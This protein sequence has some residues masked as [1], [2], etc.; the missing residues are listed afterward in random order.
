M[1]KYFVVV[2]PRMSTKAD[3]DIL[4]KKMVELKASDLFFFGNQTATIHLNSKKEKLTSRVITNK[5]VN[6]VL[7]DF[8]GIGATSKLAKPEAINTDLE[9]KEFTDDSKVP[10]RHRFRVSAVLSKRGGRTCTN[11][12]IRTITATPP[13][14]SALSIPNEIVDTCVT[15]R[16]GLILVVGGTGNGKSTTLAAIIRHLLEMRNANKHF[17]TIEEPIEYVYDS[18]SSPD[19]IFTQME[20]GRCVTSFH[21]GMVYSLRMAPTDILIGE[22]RDYETIATAVNASVTGHNVYSTA[23]ANSAAEALQRLI[24]E[25]P[26]SLQ[27]QGQQNIIQALRMIVAQR[28]VPTVDG[29]RCAVREYLIF[30]KEVKEILSYSKSIVSDT[31][32]LV[33]ERGVTM[34]SDALDKFNKGIISKDEL[35]IIKV[36]YGE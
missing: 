31:I 15:S 36:N 29:K 23:H 2:P 5:E 1:S 32:R 9:Y 16:Q 24:A 3:L 17:V 6:D 25:Y 28:L 13:K 20:V 33:K 21:T 18:V 8:Y 27:A 30:D 19:S 22:A 11:I 10:I 4:L 14:I 35:E 34:Y 12:I 26:E 7:T